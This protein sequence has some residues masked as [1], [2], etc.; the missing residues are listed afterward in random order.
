MKRN[1]LIKKII[2]Y[3]YLPIQLMQL[4]MHKKVIVLF[5]TEDLGNYG[6]QH[7]ALSELE[8]LHYYFKDYYIMEVP[9][10]SVLRRKSLLNYKFD[11]NVILFSQ[12]GGNLGDQ[13]LLGE[14]MRHL[15]IS[16][17]PENQ[18]FIFPQ[19]VYYKDEDGEWMRKDKIAFNGNA[20]VHLFIR[21]QI[22][23]EL[24]KKYFQCDIRL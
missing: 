1:G 10:T 15:A 9:A 18:Y 6:D 2:H 8:F 7:I 16:L 20:K 14:R 5:G 21:E 3:I 23:Y 17:H 4:K 11:H 22:S 12:G 19:T 24:A 13:Y